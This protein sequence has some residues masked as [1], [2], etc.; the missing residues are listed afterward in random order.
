MYRSEVKAERSVKA[1]G[2]PCR[3]FLFL[4]RKFAAWRMGSNWR[5]ALLLV[6]LLICS[7]GLLP[8]AFGVT[9]PLLNFQGRI[10]VGGISYIHVTASS[11]SDTIVAVS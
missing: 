2:N 1:E 7:F 6:T 8:V 11:Q 10:V 3:S 9:P 4:I 5:G